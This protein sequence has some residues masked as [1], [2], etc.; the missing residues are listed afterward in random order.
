MTNQLTTSYRT[1]GAGTLRR[2]DVGRIVVLCGW[3]HRRRDHGGLV[4]FDLRDRYGLVQCVAD[5]EA[6]SSE[7]YR[8]VEGLRV[9]DV[10][11]VEGTVRERP[12]GTR[13]AELETGEIE[14]SLSNCG[15]LSEAA[16][17]PFP[18]DVAK[19]GGEVSED[20]RLRYRFLE[21]R[22]PQLR[23]A[24]GMRH[25]VAL[26]TRKYFDSMGFWEIETPM[27]TRRTPEGARD[28][29]VPSRVHP[30]KFY[31]LPQSPQLYKQLL[32]IAGYDR[33]FQLARCFRDEDLR[34]DRQPEFTQVDVEMAFV[35]QSD[36]LEMID[37]LFRHLFRACLDVEI[38][39]IPRLTFEEAMT[40]YGSDKPDLRIPNELVD[41]TRAFANS[42][43]RVFDS[44]VESGGRIVALRVPEGAE[45]SR[46]VL[47]RWTDEA[48]A[49]GAKGLVWAKRESDGW[50]SSVDKY[51]DGNH[52]DEAGEA[53]G[54]S[55]GDLL[56]AIADTER[57]A[58]TAMGA[59]RVRLGRERGWIEDRQA[60]SLAWVIDF[61]LLQM[62][63]EGEL[64]PSNH[65][66]TSPHGGL[67][68]LEAEDVL[69]ILAKSYDLVLDGYELGSG[70]IRIHQREIQEKV[71]ELLG[72]DAE[73]AEANFGFLLEAFE[74]GAPPHGGIA[75]G[76][77]RIAML[78]AEA[79]SLRE[80]IAFPK[81][82][83]ASALL[84]RAPSQAEEA[85]L[86]E[87]H[88]RSVESTE[89]EGES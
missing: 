33:Y 83:S 60:W 31:A 70:T 45:A 66:F 12:E 49:T 64:F 6:M 52:W 30:G 58:Q 57:V 85:T 67:E 61:P 78:F 29:L 46:S 8:T 59:L 47:D 9:E 74:Y 50:R 65:P 11:R 32:M 69:G 42:G 19:E 63:E 41:V 44:V 71:F 28:Y 7:A 2:P 87:L 89:G 15:L 84:E 5:P 48:R 77:D 10:A 73:T 56:L 55:V 34:A 54:A 26:E 75:L 40:R 79:T 13:N 81:T 51:V 37:G 27:L 20:I 24:L 23:D 36:V 1:D 88:I 38:G 76:L 21:L 16:T 39:D 25:R 80:V 3:V 72:I 53:C 68:A 43:F 82:T 62:D 17:P 18:I 35:D 86:S 14:V 22:R 4:F